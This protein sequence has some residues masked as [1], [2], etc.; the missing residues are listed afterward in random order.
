M[1]KT[2]KTIPLKAANDTFKK[3]VNSAT[4]GNANNRYAETKPASVGSKGLDDSATALNGKVGVPKGNQFSKY[5]VAKPG[6]FSH[7]VDDARVVAG[8]GGKMEDAVG[9]LG[10]KTVATRR[11]KRN[12]KF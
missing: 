6:E 10:P 1:A 7:P 2:I 11:P 9:T 8:T 5:A 3:G 4:G 12:R